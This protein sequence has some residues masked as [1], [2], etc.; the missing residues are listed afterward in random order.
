MTIP[1]AS[2]VCPTC[3]TKTGS[4]AVCPS[5]GKATP[6]PLG[7]APNDAVRDDLTIALPNRQIGRFKIIGVIGTGGFATVY[8]AE[9]SQL[10]RQ[11]ALKLLHAHL[12]GDRD[13]TR[14][15]DDEVRASAQLSHRNI[16][17]IYDAAQTEDGRPYLV[18]ELLEGT[19]LSQLIAQRGPLPPSEALSIIAQ[20]ASALDYLHGHGLVHRDLKPSNVMI[21]E[22]GIAT[23]LDFGIVRSLYDLEQPHLTLPGN[24]V[25]TPTYIAP[26]QVAGGDVGPAADIYSLGVVAFELL[27]GRP[28]FVGTTQQILHSHAYEPP[29]PLEG[30]PDGFAAAVQRALDKDPAKRFPTAG[31]FAAALRQHASEP[32]QTQGSTRPPEADKA[33]PAGTDASRITVAPPAPARS[34]GL[35]RRWVLSLVVAA[36]IATAL[37]VGVLL[38]RHTSRRPATAVSRP[39]PAAQP[40]AK[41]AATG[42]A[43]APAAPAGATTMR[44]TAPANG[45]SVNSVVVVSVEESGAT[46][47]AATA[48]DPSAAHFHYFIDRDPAT[49]LKPGQPIPTGQPDIIHTADAS[50]TIP[51]LRPGEHHVWIVLAHT[52]HT[53]YSPNIQ[54]EVSFTVVPAAGAVQ[55]LAG[56]SSPG[57][58]DGPANAARFNNP[59]GLAADSG[60]S[61]YVADTG[62]SRVRR[63]AP[64]GTVTTVA[65]SGAGQ[66]DRPRG[67]AVDKRGTVFVADTG[68]NRIRR[69][70]PDGAITTFAGSDSPGLG[71]GGLSDGQGSAAQFRLP[72][73]IAIDGSG[74]LYVADTGNNAVRKVTADG[75]VTTLAGGSGGPNSAGFADG[76]AASARFN[77]PRG[78]AVDGAGNVYVADTLNERIRKIA[79]GGIVSTVAGSGDQGTASGSA[80]AARFSNPDGIAVDE[81]GNLYVSDNSSFRLRKILPSGIVI[82]LAGSAREGFQDG[83]PDTA[84]FDFPA[85][86]AVDGSGNV[87]VA[88]SGNNRIRKISPFKPAN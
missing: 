66:F 10:G 48:N 6:N 34:R 15:F 13:F 85:G 1:E 31:Q 69:I 80:A 86:V 71:A 9:D 78:V 35:N 75:A 2:Q 11:V 23:L 24:I 7:I 18:M 26:E 46:I 76:P 4:S 79:P 39:S 8:R 47:K 17:R 57:F 73:G 40:A 5:C 38:A 27:V 51:N 58:V 63:V 3:G 68:N 56:S 29:P 50:L 64:D 22:L 20:L 36:A 62:N 54:A 28:P 72:E 88:D 74:N 37:G 49:V 83:A 14:R 41:P 61:I 60:G 81:A 65:G 12:A 33:V 53:P 16:V 42:A 25:G 55:T 84:E 82:D 70:A 67:I 45:A 44:V 32:A 30:V 59:T 87:F 43:A 52:D 19:L 77:A 21:D